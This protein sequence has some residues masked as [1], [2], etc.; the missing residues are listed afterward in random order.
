METPPPPSNL[1]IA[2]DHDN[3]DDNGDDDCAIDDTP[4]EH[5]QPSLAESKRLIRAATTFLSI[6]NPRPG[7]PSRLLTSD[8]DHNT[9]SNLNC[10]AT[11]FVSKAK[12]DVAAVAISQRNSGVQAVTVVEVDQILATKNS[13]RKSQKLIT[14]T[15]SPVSPHKRF[16]LDWLKPFLKA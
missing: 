9:I 10:I 15:I 5:L 11:L 3:G 1:L 13:A 6:L 16:G 2:D 14:P 12:A 4:S 7:Q 8:P